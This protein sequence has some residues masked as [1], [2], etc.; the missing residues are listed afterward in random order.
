[1]RTLVYGLLAYL[2]TGAGMSLASEDA[3]MLAK[4]KYLAKAADCVACHTAPGKEP[5]AGG[6]AFELPFGTLYSPNITPDRETGI[7]GW[8]DEQFVKAL[9]EGIG[10]EG[11][12][13]YPAFP[14]TSYTKM[15]REDILAIKAYLFSLDPVEQSAPENDIAFPFNQRWGLYF[16]NLLFLDE[17]RFEPDP[18]RS[19]DWNRGAY[20]VTG[21]GHCGEC[22]TPRNLFQAMD[23]S[24]RLAGADLGGWRAYNISGSDSHGIGTWT[25]EQL[26]NYFRQGYAEGLGVAGGPMAEV[27]ELSLRHLND[28]DLRAI[29]TYLKQTE[30]QATGLPRPTP[31]ADT[32]A[33]PEQPGLGSKVFAE[34]CASCHQW[35]GEGNQSPA[36]TLAGLK[37]VHDPKA[38]NLMGILMEGNPASSLP[39]SHR[40][41]D[42]GTIYNAYEL[43]ALA[44][45]VLQH[46]GGLDAEVT[47]EQ[48]RERQAAALH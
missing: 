16:W 46:F 48:I 41:P 40:M 24:E 6:V 43:S 25:E 47:P 28:R 29:A 38:R 9:Q 2:M 14:Y 35:N 45:F 30:P 44:T 26:V 12:H 22:H 4:G 37:T 34:A 31:L 3:A 36:A 20:L 1:M 13:Y 5:Y 32:L 7:G 11:D 39:V 17:G 18:D 33:A 42:F 8:S 21:P 23:S 10:P 19:E 27:V 15:P